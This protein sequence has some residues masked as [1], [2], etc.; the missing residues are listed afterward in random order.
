MG[1]FEL[2]L[3]VAAYLLSFYSLGLGAWAL[4]ERAW[5]EA[6]RLGLRLLMVAIGQL[7]LTA[8]LVLVLGL[9][10]ALEAPVYLAG[11]FLPGIAALYC[12]RSRPPRRALHRLLGRGLRLLVGGPSWGLGWLVALSLLYLAGHFLA[13][14]QDIDALSIHG[15]QIVEWYQSGG[16]S[17]G[18]HWNY[19]QVW[20]YQF[21]PVF[22]LLRGDLL[23][24]L[25]GLLSIGALFLAGRELAARLRL[26][27]HAGYLLA[28]FAVSLWVVW[29]D[30]FKNDTIFAS[31]L[32]LGILVAERALRRP[33]AGLWPI[34][35]PAFLVL[36]TKPSGFAYA[37][38]LFGLCFA[39]TFRRH[40]RQGSAFP[41]RSWPRFL[42]ITVLFQLPA[43]AVQLR[44]AF[45]NGNPFYPVQL[46]IGPVVLPGKVDLQGT[47]IL[48][49]LGEIETWRAAFAGGQHVMGVL[50][51]LPLLLLAAALVESAF[52][53]R[54]MQ[55]FAR[56]LPVLTCLLFLLYAATPW[57][58]GPVPGSS[59]YL[60][61]GNS[62]RYAIA[63]L[64][65]ACLVSAASLHR[66]LGSRRLV[67]AFAASC[68]LLI[69]I[70]WRPAS[71]S[72][73]L[74]FFGR[75][76]AAGL[77]SA[78]LGLAFRRVWRGS[79]RLWRKGAAALAAGSLLLAF[80]HARRLETTR[81]R[82]W[83]QGHAEVWTRVWQEK[84]GSKIAINH[85]RPIYRY[86]LHGPHF[87]NRLVYVPI[88]KGSRGGVPADAALYYVFSAGGPE[89]LAK[90]VATLETKGWRVAAQ[91]EPGSAALLE[92]DPGAAG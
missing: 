9:A 76:L 44:N 56:F 24:V 64:C 34:E 66:W 79:R 74:V 3:R 46:Q 11:S 43:A 14:P 83:L 42:T 60:A 22:L 25:P 36:G 5:P 87:Q 86:I 85:P 63:P 38:L 31:G 65:L 84:I 35:L 37:L 78:V 71:P 16:V 23:A 72:E 2:L 12:Q 45:V 57:S 69:L 67:L 32:L 40:R 6:H 91:F 20:E 8:M 47:S 68:P 10:G 89:E 80:L 92:R 4:T 52:A 48:E 18:S 21:V 75:F 81:E 88:E 13:L 58:A 55:I 61:N 51:P 29:R 17:L 1:N 30:V 7:V 90:L 28:V 53:R 39:A 73:S 49:H 70:L 54:Q 26:P 19:P 41:W 27:G 33:A 59:A 62:L 82:L 15:P 50:W 77:L